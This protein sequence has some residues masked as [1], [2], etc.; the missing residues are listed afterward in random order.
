MSHE[1]S[2]PSLAFDEHLPANAFV[3]FTTPPEPRF[4]DYIQF[5]YYRRERQGRCSIDFQFRQSCSGDD[6]LIYLGG[7]Q[8]WSINGTFLVGGSCLSI[9][10]SVNDLLRQLRR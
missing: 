8:V 6:Q 3:P 1:G 9:F 4:R 2:K 7:L 5:N 10:W